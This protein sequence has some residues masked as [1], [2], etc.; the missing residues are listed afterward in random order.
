MRDER[1]CGT[2]SPDDDE[3]AD[4]NLLQVRD[5]DIV[6]VQVQKERART[7]TARA[8]AV[9]AWRSTPSPHRPRVRERMSDLSGLRANKRGSGRRRSSARPVARCRACCRRTSRR[10]TSRSSSAAPTSC[11]PSFGSAY[12][13]AFLWPFG[14]WPPLRRV[15]HQRQL[16]SARLRR[17]AGPPFVLVASGSSAG[18]AR[19]R[20]LLLWPR[21]AAVLGR[22]GGCDRH[23]GTT[24]ST[25]T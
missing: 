1:D 15:P 5:I 24:T 20:F 18:T 14:G 12:A 19:P 13:S 22:Q 4:G 2:A 17:A 16:L 9:C 23:A 11:T 6:F 25:G 10:T 21:A 7:H 8:Y 3:G